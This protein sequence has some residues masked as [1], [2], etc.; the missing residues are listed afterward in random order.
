MAVLK[1]K[2][3]APSAQARACAVCIP[4]GAQL[5]LHGITTALQQ[6]YCLS[7]TEPV[8]FRQLSANAQT[9]RDAVEFK[10]GVKI[11]LQDLEEG[12]SV[13]V[14]ALSSEK[15]GMEDTIAIPGEVIQWPDGL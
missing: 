11:R 6:I 13:E 7:A 2:F 15:T 9:Y 12:Q 4:D 5:V 14:L 1:R 3:A 8:K 10:N